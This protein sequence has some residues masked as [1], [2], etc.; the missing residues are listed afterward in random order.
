MNNIKN[1]WKGIKFIIIIRNL[2]SDI[3]VVPPSP[4]K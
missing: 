2:S 1:T 4:I 3:A